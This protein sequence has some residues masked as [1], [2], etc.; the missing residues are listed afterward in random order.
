M[1]LV[2]H[3]S[4]VANADAVPSRI[5]GPRLAGRVWRRAVIVGFVSLLGCAAPPSRPSLHEVPERPRLAPA[6]ERTALADQVRRDG[7]AAWSEA[8]ALRSRTG[9]TALPPPA[10]LFESIEPPPRPASAPAR[11]PNPEAA[12]VAERVRSESD[13]GS[14]N[15]F[16]RQLV[17]RQPSA[18]AFE[19]AAHDEVDEPEGQPIR[20]PP[21]P[22][23]PALD[24]FLDHLGGKLAVG[25]PAPS[26]PAPGSEPD[27][28]PAA[29][30]APTGPAGAVA[31]P[32]APEPT[33]PRP[34]AA[35]TP[36]RQVTPPPSAERARPAT[37]APAGTPP[38]APRT[39]AVPPER[40]PAVVLPPPS[41][42]GTLS[43]AA[44]AELERLVETARQQG[45]ALEVVGRGA[46]PALALDR[47]RAVARLVVELGVPAGGLAVRAGGPGEAVELYLVE[48]NPGRGG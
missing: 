26:E 40:A 5:L 18:E 23:A 33:R 10:W 20:R 15:S 7:A 12:I 43:P 45:A 37:P 11:P 38:P 28:A 22:D 39:A 6:A 2:D 42:A 46:R 31:V 14:L 30:T 17:R 25:R 1:R 19:L 27:A 24:R 3:G 13:D 16:L 29:P 47:A 8:Q 48:G 9:K 32:S 36:A 41:A 34:A 21:P 44:R 35:E 4:A